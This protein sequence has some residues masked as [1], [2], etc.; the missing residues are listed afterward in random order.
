MTPRMARWVLWISLIVILP[1]PIMSDTVVLLPLGYF[2][3]HFFHSVIFSEALFEYDFLIIMQCLLWLGLLYTLAFL[4]GK[5]SMNWPIKLR[6]S[7]MSLVIFIGLI[8]CASIPVYKSIEHP[9]WVTFMT[10][11][12]PYL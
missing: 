12:E 6:G 11:Y 8:L 10:I 9:Q 4:Y 2:I 7:I 3:Q 5:I 1:L